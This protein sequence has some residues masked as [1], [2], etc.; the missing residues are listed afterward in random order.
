MST[1]CIFRVRITPDDPRWVGAWWIG[2]VLA[3]VLFVLAAIPISLFG[4][5][6]PSKWNGL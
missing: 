5:E 6:L 2:F 4:A 1:F 3:S